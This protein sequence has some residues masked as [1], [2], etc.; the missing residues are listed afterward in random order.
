MSSGRDLK[1]YPI[2]FY[3]SLPSLEVMEDL[4][5]Q[6]TVFGFIAS[7]IMIGAGSIWASKLWGSYWSWDPVETW[8]LLSWLLYGTIIHLKLIFKWGGRRVAWMLVFAI[9]TVVISFWGVNFIT[10]TVHSF[11]LE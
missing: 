11:S 8:S 6:Y 10:E 1:A 5:F 4:Q 9:I 3:D 2:P 7:A